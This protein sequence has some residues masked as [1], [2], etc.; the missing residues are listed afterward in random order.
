M[1]DREQGYM[2][3]KD[4]QGNS[5]KHELMTAIA[6]IV[7]NELRKFKHPEEVFAV[8][9]ELLAYVKTLKDKNVM[10]DRRRG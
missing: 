6:A 9:R 5:H 4:R 1:E 3:T 10:K 8:G 2:V 7:S